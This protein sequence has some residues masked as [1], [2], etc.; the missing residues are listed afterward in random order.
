LTEEI[1]TTRYVIDPAGQVSGPS[2]GLIITGVIGGLFSLFAVIALG[3]G[4]SLSSLWGGHS[5]D[6]YEDFYG[7]AIGLGSS[8]LG[9]LVAIFIIYAALKMKDLKHWNL[10]VVAS[11]LAMIPC[12]SPCC[13]IGLP[14]GIWSLVVLMRPDVKAAFK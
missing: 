10:A 12:I 9:L 8:S 2:V 6:R 4:L 14:I 7:G 3:I 1:K 11:V 5:F 13:I